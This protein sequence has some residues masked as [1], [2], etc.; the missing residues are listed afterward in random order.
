MHFLQDG[1]FAFVPYRL[2]SPHIIQL[3]VKQLFL[4]LDY[5]FVLNNT[6]LNLEFFVV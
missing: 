2:P 3:Q 4:G 1:A 5:S 6:L